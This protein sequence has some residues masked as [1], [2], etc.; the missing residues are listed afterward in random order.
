MNKWGLRFIKLLGYLV[1]A[2]AIAFGVDLYRNNDVPT[3]VPSED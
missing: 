3:T 2:A 1:V